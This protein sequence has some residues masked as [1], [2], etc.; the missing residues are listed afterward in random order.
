MQTDQR[1]LWLSLVKLHFNPWAVAMP[2]VQGKGGH[3]E[4]Y[5]RAMDDRRERR[6]REAAMVRRDRER[7]KLFHKRQAIAGACHEDLYTR[8]WLMQRNL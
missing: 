6:E 7:L 5:R 3:R 4:S 1:T 2:Q 8:T